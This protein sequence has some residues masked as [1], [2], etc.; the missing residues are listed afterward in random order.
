MFA[1]EL[2]EGVEPVA[3][4][5]EHAVR[6]RPRE[7]APLEEGLRRP[8]HAALD[9]RIEVERQ[10]LD[11]PMELERG[12]LDGGELSL[13]F[14]LEKWQ[15][16]DRVEAMAGHRHLEARIHLLGAPTEELVERE[17]GEDLARGR[18]VRGQEGVGPAWEATS[19]DL[20]GGFEFALA[21]HEH[22]EAALGQERRTE[23][24]FE[25]TPQ[26]HDVEVAASHSPFH[27]GR[28]PRTSAPVATAW[29]VAGS[30]TCSSL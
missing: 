10:A 15:V 24:P 5:I 16:E 23:Q 7:L 3:L 18:A 30:K 17:L 29:R 11:H 25:A 26:D 12:P 2:G 20:V 21:Q 8:L 28:A 27:C 14:T 1:G 22:A 6:G 19:T 4:A 9:E 13:E